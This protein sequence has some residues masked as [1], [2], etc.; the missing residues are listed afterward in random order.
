[1]RVVLLLGRPIFVIMKYILILFFVNFLTGFTN[2]QVATIKGKVVDEKNEPLFGATI[3][4]RKDITIGTHSEEDGTFTL[5]VPAGPGLLI[6]KFAGLLADTVNFNIKEGEVRNF[7]FLLVEFITKVEGI[8]IV[9]T[10]NDIPVSEQIVSLQVLRPELLENRGTRTIE[11]ALDQTPGLNIM[12]GEPQIRGGSGFTAGV[13]SKVAVMVDDMPMLS[14]DAGRAEWAFIPVENISQVEV[15]KGAAS[16]LS[17]AQ[18]LS[19][20]INIRTAYPTST[21][22]TKINVYTGLYSSPSEPDAKWWTG[23]PFMTGASFLHSR[24]AGNWDLV[25]GANVSHDHNY[26]GPPKTDEFVIDTVTQFS[27]RQMST[28]RARMN[29]NIRHRSKKYK[30]LSYGVNGNLMYQKQPMP[31]AWLNDSSGL[32]S[33]YPGAVFLQNQFVFHVDPFVHLLTATSGKH[34]LRGRVMH[35]DSRM[36][37]NQDTKTTTYYFDYMYQ[38]KIVRLKDL[39][40]VGGVTSTY[41]DSY[42]EMYVGSGKPNNKMLNAA[43]YVQLDK[44][45]MDVLQVN[46]GGRLEYFDVNG[47]ERSFAP[48]VRGGMTLKVMQETYFRASYGQGYRFP[49]ITERFIRTGVGSFGIFANPDLKAEKSWNAEIGIKQGVKIGNVMGYI[50]IAGFWSHYDNTI[51]YLFG[52]WGTSFTDLSN[53]F[54]F[55]FV[56]TGESRV[57]GIDASFT[58]KA[59]FG[60]NVEAMYMIGYNY[61]LPQSLSPDY[62][63]AVDTFLNREYSYEQTSMNGD[64]NILKYR[65]LHNFKADVEFTLFNKVGIGGSVKYFSKME[66]MDGVLKE[67]EEATIG[68]FTQSIRY[69]DYF[70]EKNKGK[71]IVDLRVS[72]KFNDIH[73]LSFICNNLLNKTYS[74]RPLKIEAPR[75]FMLQ[76]TVKLEGKPKVS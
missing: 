53:A 10:K 35:S 69:I 5:E 61:V 21:P 64:R 16:V 55:K 2:A 43:G 59:D 71:W 68:P 1:M 19:G 36:T 46:I 54:G 63:Y 70:L 76:Y 67:F 33:S 32:F 62:V 29:F 50:D 65:F 13:G 42:A 23:V 39:N 7:D 75:S 66:N 47:D 6:C 15:V 4:Y 51:E 12:D 38:N 58:G 74:L 52:F 73:K 49:T 27:N 28:Q 60:K 30:G 25:F 45:F 72:Y 57:I 8:Q 37:S 26:I 24:K 3:V 9:A 20:S 40:F 48:I 14:G 44:K 18:A 41:V 11:T 31:M 34:Y 17:G 22:V 56:N